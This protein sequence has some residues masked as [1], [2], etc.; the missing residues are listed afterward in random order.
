MF[1]A[2]GTEIQIGN[3]FR[4]A[5]FGME[6]GGVGSLAI[7]RRLATPMMAVFRGPAQ[8]ARRPLVAFSQLHRLMILPWPR[9]PRHRYP[10]EDALG[11]AIN[12]NNAQHWVRPTPNQSQCDEV[13]LES[14]SCGLG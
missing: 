12:P 14:L 8:C 3:T 13:S 10:G 5:G 1:T 4:R 9:V 11:I 6:R 2:G 7:H